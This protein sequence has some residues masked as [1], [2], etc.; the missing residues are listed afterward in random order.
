MRIKKAKYNFCIKFVHMLQ[1]K[2]HR[3]NDNQDKEHKY[4]TNM[5]P[6]WW[7]P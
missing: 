6:I 4:L 7:K 1:T 2:H 3:T 5:R